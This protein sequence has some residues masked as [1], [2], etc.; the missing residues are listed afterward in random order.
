MHVWLLQ[1]TNQRRKQDITDTVYTIHKFSMG[2]NQDPAKE[3]SYQL[4][5][6]QKSYSKR[7]LLLYYLSR[8][9]RQACKT[10]RRYFT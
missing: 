1:Q 10:S 3:N 2:N 8:E 7:V 6:S 4:A 9:S 5:G